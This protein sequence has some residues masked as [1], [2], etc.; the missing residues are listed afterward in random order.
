MKNK[1]HVIFIA[2]CLVLAGCGDNSRRE[3]TTKGTSA[4]EIEVFG[5]DMLGKPVEMY[6]RFASIDNTCLELSSLR[7]RDFVGFYVYD[8]KGELFAHAFADKAALGRTLLDLRRGQ[9]ILL[10][11]ELYQVDREYFFS[12]KEITHK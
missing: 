10:R 6:C 7:N 5:S 12:V 2:S 4:K 9:V 11:G 1:L 8:K 3:P